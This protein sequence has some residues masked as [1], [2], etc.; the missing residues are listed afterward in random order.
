[1]I[2]TF[3]LFESELSSL[4]EVKNWEDY[5]Q[6]HIDLKSKDGIQMTDELGQT[7]WNA[8]P[9]EN[10]N[11]VKW[12]FGKFKQM[13]Y[14]EFV[15]FVG[16]IFDKLTIYNSGKDRISKEFAT[17][18]NIANIKT[19]EQLDEIVQYIVDNKLNISKKLQTKLTKV[20]IE[21]DFIK[22]PIDSTWDIII[23]LT[24]EQSRYWAGWHDGEA[25]AKWC[26][27][28]DNAENRR[29]G[30]HWKNYTS[31]GPLYIFKNNENNK[32]S[33]QLWLSNK[34]GY[35][36][37]NFEDISVS[38]DGFLQTFKSHDI[39]K[40]I[41]DFWNDYLQNESK[42]PKS[43]ILGFIKDSLQSYISQFLK[44]S[45]TEH[46]MLGGFILNVD[47]I[48]EGDISDKNLESILIVA[49]Q[50]L[51]TRL[52]K[53]FFD[54]NKEMVNK[55]LSN[56]MTPLMNI[57]GMTNS[58]I[59]K[60]Q[61]D[62]VAYKICEYLITLGADGSGTRENGSSN[63]VLE[64]LFQ[65]NSK[66]K[67]AILL[68]TLPNYNPNNGASTQNNEITS[69]TSYMLNVNI[70][71]K[72]DVSKISLED[73]KIILKNM[74]E[75]GLRINDAN[76]GNRI[77]PTL[78][79]I[80]FNIMTAKSEDYVDNLYRLAKAF[81][82]NGANPCLGFSIRQG[83]EE[84]KPIELVNKEKHMKFYE[85]FAEYMEINGCGL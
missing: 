69:A 61:Q 18:K 24:W 35:E 84:K 78:V 47:T 34:G 79:L 82:E 11:Y 10:K 52:I 53:K 21:T 59:P 26:T 48:I 8:D 42:Y 66:F 43:E 33:H 12:I 9:T 83:M 46:S 81:L 74:V 68:S 45:N 17:W 67:T 7:V 1:M 29:G 64:C 60:E 30:G 38:F 31:Q 27:A 5:R 51:N 14:D 36:F 70:G 23:P 62:E 56:K 57:V 73:F 4:L 85:L 25:G 72:T 63:V 49:L 32:L 75:R 28:A 41:V 54:S 58:S 65:D 76:L 55:P 15:E 22:I 80:I 20:A 50:S 2:T 71:D 37:R 6:Y 19:I 39:G 44:N 13:N 3:N 40:G 16:S 77:T